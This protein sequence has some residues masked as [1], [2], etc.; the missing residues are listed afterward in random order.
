MHANLARYPA[1]PSQAVSIHVNDHQVGRTHP[2]LANARRRHQHPLTVQ[3]HRE[4]AIG[5]GNESIRVQQFSE[6]DDGDTMFAFTAHEHTLARP[7]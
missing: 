5:G 1:L 2:S 4:I 7:C 6:F 3:A